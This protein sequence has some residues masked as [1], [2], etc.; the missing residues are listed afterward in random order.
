MLT[1]MGDYWKNHTEF[2]SD[3]HYLYH[4]GQEALK[5][6]GVGFIVINLLLKINLSSSSLCLAGP[7][8]LWDLSS[9][10]RD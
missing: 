1:S 6:N 10:I 7:C 4:C 9:L 5:R 2:N 3:D 8:G